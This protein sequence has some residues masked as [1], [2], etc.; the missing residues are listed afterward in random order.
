MLHKAVSIS[1]TMQAYPKGS[2]K[3]KRRRAI[4]EALAREVSVVPPSRLMGLLE[5][6]GVSIQIQIVLLILILYL[7]LLLVYYK[8]HIRD[9]IH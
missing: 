4:A 9:C 2:S 3:E 7:I 8:L 5:Q 1:W 6:V